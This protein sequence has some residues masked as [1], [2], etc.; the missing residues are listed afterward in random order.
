MATGFVL[1]LLFLLSLFFASL[2]NA[3][4]PAWEAGATTATAEWIHI[5]PSWDW[6]TWYRETIQYYFN[7]PASKERLS[8]DIRAA[9]QLWLAAGL[10]ETFR[11]VEF[12]KWRCEQ[13]PYSCLLIVGD[14]EVPSAY[15]SLGRQVSHPWDAITMYLVFEPGEDEHSRALIAAHEIGHAWGLIHEHQNPLYWQWAYYA[16]RSDSLFRFYCANVQ[17]YDAVAHEINSTRELWGENGPCRNSLRASDMD[18]YASEILPWAHRYQSPHHLWPQDSD[19]DW[20]SIMIY[21]SYL[22]GELDEHGN[23]KPTLLRMK[24]LQVIPDP[25]TVTDLDVVGLLHLYHPKFGKFLDVFHNEP[26]SPWYTIFQGKIKSCP[27]KT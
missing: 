13:H 1:N 27:I 12:P 21:G 16:T 18:F 20:D 15:T 9:W 5:D 24:D 6:P 25:D 17:G 10:P 14:G 23:P 2:S 8:S 7:S 26:S 3:G 22:F 19:V 4:H 11:F